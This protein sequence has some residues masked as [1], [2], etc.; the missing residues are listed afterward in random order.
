VRV[1]LDQARLVI[2]VQKNVTAQLDLLAAAD[3]RP[4]T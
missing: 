3:K 1:E 4:N 2:E